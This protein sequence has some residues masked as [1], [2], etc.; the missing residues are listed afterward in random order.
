MPSSQQP[1]VV[2]HKVEELLAP[3]GVLYV[4]AMPCHTSVHQ[5]WVK[6]FHSFATLL[7]KL[8]SF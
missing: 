4:H 3:F 7:K 6:Y 1:S 2:P 8:N 5:V